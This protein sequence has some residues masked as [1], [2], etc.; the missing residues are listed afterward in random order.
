MRVPLVSKRELMAVKYKT[1]DRVRVSESENGNG[2]GYTGTIG[3]AWA[4]GG[5]RMY[6]VMPSGRRGFCRPE[7]KSIRQ[8]ECRSKRW[9]VLDRSRCRDVGHISFKEERDRYLTKLL[10][11]EMVGQYAR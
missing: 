2:S 5:K 9:D 10:R 8:I 11:G 6:Q 3:L 1:G 4:E 7:E